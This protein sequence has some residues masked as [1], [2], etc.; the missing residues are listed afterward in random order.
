MNT[1]NINKFYPF[2]IVIRQIALSESSE[3]GPKPKQM[4]DKNKT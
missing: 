3:I 2:D 4:L 1:K